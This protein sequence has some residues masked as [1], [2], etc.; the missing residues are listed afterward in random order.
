MSRTTDSLAGLW[1]TRAR[2]FEDT[3][4]SYRTQ[5]DIAL[6]RGD[7]GAQETYWQHLRTA[8][9][10]QGQADAHRACARQLLK[11]VLS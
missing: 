3:A 8:A 5:A 6:G 7:T 11:A 4:A 1:N 9:W 2:E 10:N